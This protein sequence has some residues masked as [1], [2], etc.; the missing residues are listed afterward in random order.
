MACS[1]QAHNLLCHMHLRNSLEM[2]RRCVNLYAH[3]EFCFIIQIDRLFSV[4]SI[5][6][7]ILL[8]K[9]TFFMFIFIRQKG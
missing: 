6:K 2:R 5:G 9:I 4:I 1:E 7:T 8:R 3:I